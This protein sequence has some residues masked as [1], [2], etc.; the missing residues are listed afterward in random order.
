MALKE[1]RFYDIITNPEQLQ[2]AFFSSKFNTSAKTYN[3]SA[4]TGLS[5][6]SCREVLQRGQHGI[7]CKC[8]YRREKNA[9]QK[10][11]DH[12]A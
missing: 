1:K 12:I 6:S 2:A 11:Y 3:N 10:L 5:A 7:E 8:S 4:V 9:L